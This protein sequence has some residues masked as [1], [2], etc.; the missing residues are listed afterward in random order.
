M[1]S[2]RHHQLRS[3]IAKPGY[4][5]RRDFKIGGFTTDPLTGE[6]AE[7]L[8]T[9]NKTIII[10]INGD[11]HDPQSRQTY[12]LRDWVRYRAIYEGC[13]AR[14]LVLESGPRRPGLLPHK[15]QAIA[16]LL[17]SLDAGI[18]FWQV[19]GP[20]R[21]FGRVAPEGAMLRVLEV[22]TK[23]QM[24]LFYRVGMD[25]NGNHF[26]VDGGSRGGGADVANRKLGQREVVCG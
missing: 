4:I 21:D 20:H 3:F 19:V 15:S 2:S 7:I 26:A 18:R 24:E 25:R 22:V 1:S 14:V 23:Q 6:P 12:L 13:L 17:S 10:A 16:K 5:R 11:R 8:G 9:T